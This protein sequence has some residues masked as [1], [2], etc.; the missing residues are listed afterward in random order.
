MSTVLPGSYLAREGPGGNPGRRRV[1]MALVADTAECVEAA[2]P[3]CPICHIPNL[4][5]ASAMT[6]ALQATLDAAWEDRA[7]FSPKIGAPKN[8]GRL[9]ST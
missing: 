6:P 5:E 8:R 3:H 4:K 7:N 2:Q 1:R 9:W